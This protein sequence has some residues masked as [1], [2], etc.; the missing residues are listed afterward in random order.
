MLTALPVGVASAA[1]VAKPA[2]PAAKP[3]AAPAAAAKPAAAKPAAGGA[4]PTDIW[5]GVFTNAQAKRGDALYA[6]HCAMCHMV[7][8]GGKEPAPELAGDNFLSKWLGHDVGELYTRVA[9]TMPAGNPGILK[10]N[11][12]ADLVALLLQANN[13]KG[14]Q[15]EMKP[16]AAALK[17]VKIKKKGT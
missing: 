12:Y 13:F 2:A 15:V 5:A 9:T 4:M 3:A 8:M 7:D 11:E 6:Q 16:D 1:D 17:Q 10:P 14:G